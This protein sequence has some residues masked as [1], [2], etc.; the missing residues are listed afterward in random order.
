MKYG[1]AN[2]I[3]DP[4]Y[5]IQGLAGALPECYCREGVMLRLV[6][7]AEMLPDGYKFVVFDG[8]RALKLQKSF[9]D[10]QRR[11]LAAA[12]PS[13]N[14]ETLDRMTVEFVSLPS[15]S[16]LHP[17]PH[18][19]G[20]ALDLSVADENGLL[21]PMGTKFDSDTAEASTSY[22]EERLAAG[23]ALSE[24]DIAAMFSSSS[25]GD[26]EKEYSSDIKAISYE[27]NVGDGEARMDAGK[28]T[29]KKV[30]VNGVSNGYFTMNH[31]KLLKG[32]SI[33]KNDDEH[34]SDVAVI[35]ESAAKSLT[36]T[37]DN[38]IGQEIR[39][40]FDDKILTYT[41]VGIYDD[42]TKSGSMFGGYN[43]NPTLYIPATAAMD[44][45]SSSGIQFFSVMGD[46]L[47]FISGKT[48]HPRFRI[49]ERADAALKYVKYGILVFC[50][51]FLWTGIIS[52]Q[53]TVS[54]WYAF[55]MQPFTL[56][57][58]FSVYS[59]LFG[60]KGILTTEGLLITAR[61]RSYSTVSLPCIC[62]P[63]SRHC[64]LSNVFTYFMKP[65]FDFAAA[66]LPFIRFADIR[67][68]AGLR[69]VSQL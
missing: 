47:W 2:I 53:S 12:D 27:E 64:P 40:V 28:E 41:I 43:S 45:N 19:T 36:S 11:R 51:V 6:R 25:I 22:Y 21:L 65:S 59:G 37:D 66:V 38:I 50:A 9:Y 68:S 23:D 16:D 63:C 54:P 17:A 33:N 69:S 13:L 3:S 31:V 35:P 5:F 42:S 29:Q 26:Y 32:R 24:S 55:G 14:E 20:G 7:A 67:V 52:I 1:P 10:E 49:P 4:Q 48:I 15:R 58:F 44:V 62:A 56:K 18:S 34:S 8:W 60:P 39:V 46:F 30:T 57:K 61:S